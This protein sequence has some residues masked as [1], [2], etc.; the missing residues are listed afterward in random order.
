MGLIAIDMVQTTSSRPGQL[1][2]VIRGI[3]K[4]IIA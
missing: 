4:Y 1:S 3:G 2:R